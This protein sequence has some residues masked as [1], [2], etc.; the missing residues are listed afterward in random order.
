MRRTCIV[1]FNRIA[2]IRMVDEPLLILIWVE[3]FF[4]L[5]LTHRRVSSEI[6]LAGFKEGALRFIN[7]WYDHLISHKSYTTIK[8]V[9]TEE[10]PCN[11]FSWLQIIFPSNKSYYIRHIHF[12][13]NKFYNN[14]DISSIVY[15]N[16]QC[17]YLFLTIDIAFQ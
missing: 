15:I 11:F 7:A 5:G 6:L 8:F 9:Y 3:F 2:Y 16:Q 4:H 10:D 12:Y 17:K 14:S 1:D 13:L